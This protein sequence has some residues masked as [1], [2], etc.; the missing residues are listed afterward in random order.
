MRRITD[1]HTFLIPLLEPRHRLLF[2][3]EALRLLSLLAHD[4]PTATSSMVPHLSQ[5]FSKPVPG[6]MSHRPRSSGANQH[7]RT[8]YIT[9]SYPISIFLLCLTATQLFTEPKGFALQSMAHPDEPFFDPIL[10]GAVRLNV[11]KRTS[12]TRTLEKKYQRDTSVRY[13]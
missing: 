1:I 5:T 13:C 11:Y 4:E 6:A 2:N 8:V 7:N 12:T 10:K 9:Y 3:W